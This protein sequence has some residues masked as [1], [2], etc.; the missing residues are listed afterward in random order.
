MR[1]N[2]IILC[3]VAICTLFSSFALAGTGTTMRVNVPFEFY[4]GDQPLPAGE[5]V[6]QMKSGAAAQG[7]LVAIHS[8]NGGAICLLATR[9]GTDFE[10]GQLRFNKYGNKH[11]LTSISI[12]GT[13]AEVPTIR[14][15]KE[16]RAQ[17][18]RDHQVQT[19][20]QR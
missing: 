12:H 7:S 20:A 1:K 13:N 8:K 10:E 5:Y 19:I 18:E 16:L 6:F 3:V 2:S 17:D 15:E 14:L 4:A 9:P 11:F